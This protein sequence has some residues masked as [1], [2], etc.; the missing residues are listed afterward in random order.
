MFLKEELHLNFNRSYCHVLSGMAFLFSCQG[1]SKQEH[2]SVSNNIATADST[3]TIRKLSPSF[4]TLPIDRSIAYIMGQFDPADRPEFDSLE[5]SHVDRP[6]M[7][8]RKDTYFYFRKMSE[9]AARDSITLVIR[10]ATRNFYLQ[11]DIWERKWSGET[12]LEDQYD[13]TKIEDGAERASAI[14]RYSS[15]PGTSRHHWG[16]DFDLNAFTNRYFEEG[17][18][19]KIYTWLSEHAHEYGF[20][21]PYSAKGEGRST[22]YEEEKWHWSFTPVASVLL[23]EAQDKLHDQDIVGFSGAEE[24]TRIQVVNNYVLGINSACLQAP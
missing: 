21:Q 13:A 22:G 4:D 18:G 11:K 15:M 1:N 16:T 20:C 12:L 2:S 19:K 17:P 3:A 6:G 7:Y 5:P 8:L 23:D 24:A 10:S 14:L 9:H